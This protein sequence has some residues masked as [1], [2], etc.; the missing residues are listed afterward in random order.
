LTTLA[1]SRLIVITDLDG[2]LLDENTYSYQ[3]SLPA[4]QG[5]KSLGVPLILCSSKT[6]GEILPLW[7][8]LALKDPFIVENGGAIYCP[9]RYFPFRLPGFKSRRPFK[10]LE[11]GTDVGT[12]REV[13]AQTAD[14]C[15]ATIRSFGTMSVE[16]ICALT[17]LTRD[18]A[19]LALKR[20]Y[21]EPFLIERGDR[22]GLFR[23]LIG[24]GFTVTG[25][26]RFFHLMGGHE[27]GKAVKILL[28]LYRRM[29]SAVM[30]MGLGD[31]AND[32]PLLLQVD[33][34]I[35]VRKTNGSYDPEVLREM[36]QVELTQ[37]MGPHGWREA[38][39]KVLS[40]LS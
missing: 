21:D 9:T 38:I 39:E 16:D 23:I 35:L 15:H 18:Q 19:T 25:G 22:E 33:R 26:D 1:L 10:V 2:T 32:L 36:P 27:K 31:S 8:E 14:R 40:C 28:D 6:H 34:P 11:L 30:S 4:I 20:E 7:K 17:G 24:K 29:D 37:A 5:L 12:L 13:L 3:A